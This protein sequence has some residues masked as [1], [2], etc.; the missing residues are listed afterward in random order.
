M[1]ARTALIAFS[2]TV[3]SSIDGRGSNLGLAPV[4][5]ASVGITRAEAGTALTDAK[6]DERRERARIAPQRLLDGVEIECVTGHDREVLVEGDLRDA[7]GEEERLELRRR[8]G[9]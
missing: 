7:G 4:I 3:G 6:D 8:A 1:V 2:Q 9:D 5:D